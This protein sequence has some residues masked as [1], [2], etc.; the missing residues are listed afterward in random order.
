M[1][2]L[3]NFKADI[4]G[5]LIRI[6][7]GAASFV[8]AIT[9][10]KRSALLTRI[11]SSEHA[12]PLLILFLTTVWL[13]R[14]LFIVGG[15]PEGNDFF[16]WVARIEQFSRNLDSLIVWSNWGFGLVQP[17]SAHIPLAILNKVIGNP[18]L[19][20]SISIAIC[21]WVAGIN[22]Y[23]LARNMGVS[24][25][26]AL[27][28][29]LVFVL[30]QYFISRFASGHL[31]FAYAYSLFPLLLLLYLQILRKDSLYFILGF[32]TLSWV[33]ISF[34]RLDVILYF[35]PILLIITIAR[36]ASLRSKANL[37]TLLIRIAKAMAIGIPILIAL[38]AFQIIAMLNGTKAAF[39]STDI[40]IPVPELLFW[41]LSFKKSLLGFSRELGVLNSQGAISWTTH[42][43]LSSIGYEV[44]MAIIP[45]LG[46]L[47][48]IFRRDW[49]V[50]SLIVTALVGAFLAKGPNPPGEEIYLWLYNNI[51]LF[52]VLKT[53]NRWIMLGYIAYPLLIG[54]TTQGLFSLRPQI[55]SGLTWIK[56]IPWRPIHI[57]LIVMPL[58]LI[59]ISLV[60]ASWY[61]TTGGI[62]TWDPPLA[63]KAPH[64]WIAQQEGIFRVATVPYFQEFM[65]VNGDFWTHDLGYSSFMYSGHPVAGIGSWKT[66][67]SYSFMS[68]THQM[69]L[70]GEKEKWA[71]LLGRYG[72]KFVVVQGY[73]PTDFQ[74]IPLGFDK[75]FQKKFLDQQKDLTI[76]FDNGT[77]LVYQN[78]SW[79]PIIKGYPAYNIH[80][81]GLSGLI[82][83]DSIPDSQQFI[84]KISLNDI[85]N[86]YSLPELYEIVELSSEIVFNQTEINDVLLKFV[87]GAISIEPT[88]FD[89]SDVPF[90]KSP[91]F[92]TKQG[93]WYGSIDDYRKGEPILSGQTL[94]TDSFAKTRTD[95]KINDAGTFDIWT[96]IKLGPSTSALTIMVNNEE[97]ARFTPWSSKNQGFKWLKVSTIELEKGTH[98]L[99]LINE[100]AGVCNALLKPTISGLKAKNKTN[101]IDKIYFVP[102]D[103][104]KKG[105]TAL[106]NLFKYKNIY[107]NE[108]SGRPSASFV[109]DEYESSS[110]D[111]EIPWK[112]LEPNKVL[113][114]SQLHTNPEKTGLEYSAFTI[115][116]EGGARAYN[117]LAQAK[118]APSIDLSNERCLTLPYKGDGSGK[119][120]SLTIF[121]NTVSL[122]I[123]PKG[124]DNWVGYN[125]PNNGSGWETI[126]FDL[127]LPDQSNGTID[128]KNV[129]LIRLQIGN[130]SYKG[131]FNIDPLRLT[132]V[133]S[134]KNAK[135]NTIVADS[136]WAP[137]TSNLDVILG[138]IS[139][140]QAHLILDHDDKEL[141]WTSVGEGVDIEYNRITNGENYAKLSID[142]E[143]ELSKKRS[144]S[145]VAES[146]LIKPANLSGYD[147]VSLPINI[148]EQPNDQE[149]YI[150]L[151]FYFS[152]NMDSWARFQI[153]PSTVDQNIYTAELSN[154]SAT[155][156]KLDWSVVSH[157]R[158]QIT[159]LEWG[160][161][162]VLGPMKKHHSLELE[163]EVKIHLDEKPEQSLRL[164]GNVFRGLDTL[165]QIKELTNPSKDSRV[166]DTNW[167]IIEPAT[168]TIQTTHNN[169]VSFT[170]IRINKPRNYSTV[171]ELNLLE[172]LDISE[173]D[174]LL[175]PIETSESDPHL[176]LVFYFSDDKTSWA[177]F[178]IDRKAIL[179]K[180]YI[181]NMANPTAFEGKVDW[182]QLKSIRL[183]L[184]PLDWKGYIKMGELSSFK[185]LT[186]RPS[187]I[188][189]AEVDLGIVDAGYHDLLVESSYPIEAGS[190]S[191][192]LTNT[193]A[194]AAPPSEPTIKS[195]REVNPG[196]YTAKI[197][198]KYP[199]MLTFSE[200]YHPQWKAIIDN[201]EISSIQTDSFINGFWMD[202]TGKY[203]VDIKFTG[204]RFA[205][206]GYIFTGLAILG[207][208][209]A[210]TGVTRYRKNFLAWYQAN[211]HIGK[212]LTKFK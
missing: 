63:E 200:A 134:D 29:A 201:R 36:F 52:G 121:F 41:S 79:Q 168:S 49:L 127:G 195:I 38:S 191:I 7:S 181:A 146:R 66:G 80:V 27:V 67:S 40:S 124:L 44:L 110:R 155:N 173:Y 9:R 176:G 116:N 147:A 190:P 26:P 17:P 150:G 174:Y 152:D 187:Y 177:R 135:A 60:T 189:N 120:L 102:S 72:I 151:V 45:I 131:T 24:R 3:S 51:P 64:E 130:K 193:N 158:L 112:V 204:Q 198:S 137:F 93:G 21:I 50:V 2:R 118:F 109:Y 210:V 171:S 78:M 139:Q 85:S 53:P 48:L 39:V 82:P 59:A 97:T 4:Y 153:D 144:A 47:S 20:L 37:R 132:N 106:R 209:I 114:E 175:L 25:I 73:D 186:V 104:Y 142:A 100:G 179:E 140:K 83:P 122:K 19:T 77:S 12:I 6:K 199:F 13:T 119:N 75:D 178:S 68:Y 111:I 23:F 162:L 43:F 167:E 163:T 192:I 87:P 128:W 203:S 90:Y 92:S 11:S 46:L 30:N 123:D 54:F 113:L 145:T 160:G 8:R 143:Q 156:G 96:R 164:G 65:K 94:S 129:S 91:Y 211:K 188:D 55:T 1:I 126:V 136:F 202:Q 125:I 89:N 161:S 74:S 170:H 81:G 165:A 207:L 69:M 5:V 56:R 149:V 84:P 133:S 57:S 105:E 99:E 28:A 18:A 166:E 196:H 42:P 208:F 148:I 184:S 88:D 117:T 15:I 70:E 138:N 33:I 32:A 197:E 62:R 34:T 107:F 172:P 159:P 115:G 61:I 95:F 183:Q 14:S 103:N 141:R 205:N 86:S 206:L 31:P 22:M 35:I 180:T 71:D 16:G 212:L 10:Q 154:P 101:D 185:S 108:I 98:S 157:I 182:A 169:E 58:S 194:S 76:V